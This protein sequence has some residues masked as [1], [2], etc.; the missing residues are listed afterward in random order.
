MV[1]VMFGGVEWAR[2]VRKDVVSGLGIGFDSEAGQ[3]QDS[4]LEMKCN[5]FAVDGVRTQ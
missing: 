2:Y 3:V 1:G 4:Q 5:E